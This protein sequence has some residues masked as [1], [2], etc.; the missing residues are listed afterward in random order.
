MTASLFARL[1]L[2]IAEWWD[3]LL[4]KHSR[5]HRRREY[6]ARLEMSMSDS[7]PRPRCEWCRSTV[8][9]LKLRNGSRICAVCQSGMEPLDSIGQ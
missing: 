6:A 9:V 5:A 2:L 4:W 3:D 1:P 8:A 7:G